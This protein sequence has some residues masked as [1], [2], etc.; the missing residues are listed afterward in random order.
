MIGQ[1]GPQSGLVNLVVRFKSR[2]RDF[3]MGAVARVTVELKRCSAASLH[4][5]IPLFLES[6]NPFSA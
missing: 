1:S 2:D 3:N 5:F 4:P 6:S